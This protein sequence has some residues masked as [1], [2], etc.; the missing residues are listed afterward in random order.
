MYGQVSHLHP[1]VEALAF[2]HQLGV[3]IEQLHVLS[4]VSVQA[5]PQLPLTCN[6]LLLLALQLVVLLLHA[7]QDSKHCK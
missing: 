4:L 5:C 3:G 1:R 6:G 7:I 2:L